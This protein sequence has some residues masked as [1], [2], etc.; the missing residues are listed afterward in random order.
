MALNANKFA[1]KL[2]DA[3]G[4]TTDAQGKPTKISTQT[5]NKAKGVIA[6]LEAGSFSHAVVTGNTVV[7]SDLE[8]GAAV[9][10]VMVLDPAP[11]QAITAQGIPPEAASGIS[12][13]NAK[14]ITYIMTGTITFEADTITGTCNNTAEAPGSLTL[15][16]GTGGKIVGLTGAGAVAAVGGGLGPEALQHYTALIDY[17]L[18]NAEGTYASGSVTGVCPAGG[19]ALSAGI[20]AGGTFS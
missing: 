9:G 2:H 11:M 8:G 20:G 12:Q 18:E 13:E 15:G 17:L 14:L 16:A 4:V 5:L 6:T 7:A 1:Q 19:G 3:L 10:G